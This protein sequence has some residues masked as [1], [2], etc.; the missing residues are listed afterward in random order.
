MPPPDKGE[1]EEDDDE[2]STFGGQCESISCEGDAIQCA[3]ARDQYKR[4]CEA[5]E[6]E[7]AESN[8]YKNNKGKE[9]SR[10]GDLPGNET[11][12]LQGRIDTSDA[13][14]AGSTGISDLSVT[15]WGQSISLPFSMLNPY[16]AALG[17]LLLAISFLLAVRIVARG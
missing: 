17:N 3:I 12:S 9:G 7:S 13:L 16:L 4:S 1:G 10:L 8:L 6:K 15:V 11:V 2:G 5:F 14:G